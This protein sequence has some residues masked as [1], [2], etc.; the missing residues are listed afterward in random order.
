MAT[1]TPNKS[2]LSN[3]AATESQN[4]LEAQIR[5][6]Y[7][8]TAY[9]HKVHQKCAGN[10]ASLQHKIKIAQLTLTAL[11]TGSLLTALFGKNQV[12]TVIGAGLST[13]L[14][15]L[16][17][18]TK[19]H[20]L[21]K[22]AQKHIDAANRLWAVRES[23]LSVLTDLASGHISVVELRTKRDELQTE[24]GAIYESAPQ[25][26][27]AAYKAAQKALKVNEELTFSDQEIDNLLPL[28]LHRGQSVR[29]DGSQT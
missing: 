28:P 5:E 15:A 9:S 7:G 17:A 22:L 1:T 14:L 11:T 12:G 18:Y 21:G 26:T 16:T 8:R 4:V 19:D 24:A 13:M 29:S 2:E 10:A 20:D 6:L 3:Q 27:S 25:T 23:Y